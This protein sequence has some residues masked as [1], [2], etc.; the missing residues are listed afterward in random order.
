MRV[1]RILFASGGKASMKMLRSAKVLMEEVCPHHQ[2]YAFTPS[3]ICSISL[4]DSN[5]LYLKIVSSE[6]VNFGTGSPS[7]RGNKST[8][9][10]I[11][12]HC[13]G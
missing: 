3:K 11:Q 10:E 8:I 4:R 13:H 12:V 2:I 1:A 7:A 5:V 9:T 6:T